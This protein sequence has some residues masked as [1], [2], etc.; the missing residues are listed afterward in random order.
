MHM[1]PHRENARVQTAPGNGA[2]SHARS[3]EKLAVA[4]DREA[5]LARTRV[6]LTPMAAPSIMGLFG[7]TIA[8]LMVGG[9]LGGWYGTSATPLI[10]WPFAL[11]AG[12]VL[13][14]I[15]AIASFRARDGVALAVHTVWGS[16]WL[17]WGVLELLVTAHMVAPIQP[18]ALSPGFGFWFITL[19]LVTMWCMIGALAQ[20]VGLFAV[21]SALTTASA[22]TAAGFFA[23]SLGTVQAGGYLFAIS[24]ILAWLVAG[25]MVLEHAYGKTV[26]PLG[27]RSKEA[28]I[29]G[30]VTTLPLSYPAGM[31]GVRAGQ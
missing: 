11:F 20:N 15:A 5:W 7:F 28:N 4:D 8:T 19:T 16:F 9:W 12:G 27:K 14:S 26:I 6:S 23:G 18:G 1:L 2:A 17:G 31:P 25:A 22:L 24:A 3:L 21:L 29:P 30:R 10:L 13:Q